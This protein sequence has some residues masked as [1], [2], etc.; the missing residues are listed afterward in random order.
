[1]LQE[2][3]TKDETVIEIDA[4]ESVAEDEPMGM[5]EAVEGGVE[6]REA[7]AEMAEEFEV[8]DYTAPGTQLN[9]GHDRK[10]HDVRQSFNVNDDL[11]RDFFH[12]DPADHAAPHELLARKEEFIAADVDVFADTHD[13]DSQRWN[14][15]ESTCGSAPVPDETHRKLDAISEKRA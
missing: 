10:K 8:V 13:A 2:S 7:A 9:H 14:S 6:V 15:I 3:K 4:G 1:M 11:V 12:F 5:L